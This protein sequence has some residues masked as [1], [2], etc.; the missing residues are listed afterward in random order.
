MK[1]H[2]F[3]ALLLSASLALPALAQQSSSTSQSQSSSQSSA[4]APDREP[5]QPVK[6]NDFWDGENPNLGNLLAHPVTTKKYVQKQMAPIRDRIN[7]LDDIAATNTHM[8]KD[9]DDRTQR[10][11]QLASSK[12]T[13]ADQHAIDAGT[14]ANSAQQAA[15]AA[16]THLTVVEQK[17]AS[18]GQYKPGSETEIRFSAGQTVLSKKAK[19]ALDEMATPLKDQNG[20]VIEIRGFAAG[21]GQIAITNSRKMA[22]AVMR[23]LVESHNVPVHR[24]YVLGMGDV[25]VEAGAKKPTSGGRVEVSLLKNELVSSNQH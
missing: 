14:R 12:T 23:Y 16:S 21:R 15:Q 22:D 1:T 3:F 19:D 7:E 17:V 5:L 2:T 11:L 8:I 6:S 18:V 25:P 13:E 24:I 10:G 9:V 20:Y 4:S